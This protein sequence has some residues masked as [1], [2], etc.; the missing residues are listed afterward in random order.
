MVHKRKVHH[1]LGGTACEGPGTEISK[2]KSS[3]FDEVLQANKITLPKGI[4]LPA[5][6][7]REAADNGGA[8]KSNINQKRNTEKRTVRRT[9]KHQ[10]L[11]PIERAQR[12]AFRIIGTGRQKG[13]EKT[14]GIK[15]V[16]YK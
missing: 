9:G 3:P 8:L 15:K 4:R 12:S 1:G 5:G 16:W 7:K 10:K 13:Q 2:G 6:R 11:A 14:V